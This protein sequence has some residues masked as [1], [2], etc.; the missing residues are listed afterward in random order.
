MVVSYAGKYKRRE[1][2]MSKLLELEKL[3]QSVWL[4]FMRRSLVTSGELQHLIEK[5]VRGVTSNPAIFEKAIGGSNDYDEDI[6]E[7]IKADKS[8]D[9]IYETL[10]FE[11]IGRAADL[12]TNV[13]ETS[14]GKDGYVSLEVNPHLAGDTE[15]T[16]EEATRLFE[17]LGRPN[18][19]IKVPATAAGIPAITTLI[20]AGVNV[21]VTLIFGLEN[22]RMVAEAYLAGLEKLVQVGPGLSGGHP[23]ERV[24]SVASF[25]VSRVDSAVDKELEKKGEKQLQGKIAIANSKLAYAEFMKIFS[26]SRWKKL[27]D[28]G[29]RRQ[30]VLWASTSTKNPDYADTL[31]VDE[32]I[33]PDTVNTMPPSTLDSFVDHGQVA[34]T[35]MHGTDEARRQ[36]EKL[37]ALDIDLDVVTR[38]LQEDGVT[39]FAEPFDALMKSIDEKRRRLAAAAG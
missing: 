14:G 6:V 21:N 1:K 20:A 23:V 32:L 24:A 11:D 38:R 12:L 5:G 17:T 19:M 16:I 2:S 7:L 26:G 36:I 8:V 22:Y 31:Y 34:E 25:F 10:A 37:A 30:R 13:Y 33:G 3:G 27:S 4:D 35:L 9:D 39:A 28:K 29:A 18:V 15:K